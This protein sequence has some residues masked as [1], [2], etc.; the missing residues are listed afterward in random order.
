MK[1]RIKTILGYY[2][3]AMETVD[4][5]YYV[6]YQEG[7]ENGCVVIFDRANKVVSDNYF[8][9]CD[10]FNVIEEK[11]YIWISPKLKKEAAKSLELSN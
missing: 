4:H 10:M 7:D 8:A 9:Y 3:R 1:K 11:S 5:V 2:Y 6:N